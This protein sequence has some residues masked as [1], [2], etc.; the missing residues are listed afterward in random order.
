V[1][2]VDLTTGQACGSEP[3]YGDTVGLV[4]VG[5][6][7]THHDGFQARLGPDKTRAELYAVRNHATLEA[8]YVQRP[9]R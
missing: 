2:P 1:I 9:K 6:L 8:L 4:L 3:N 5:Y 7:V